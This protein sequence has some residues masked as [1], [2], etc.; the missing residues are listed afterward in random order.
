MN[1]L[2]LKAILSL[3]GSGFALGLKRAES[4]SKQFAK[5]IKGEFARAFGTAALVAYTA[6]LANM[7]GQLT[8]TSD[9]LGISTKA[10]QEWAY[11]A[12]QSGSSL[13]SITRYLEE[14][15]LAR[16]KALGGDATALEAFRKLGVSDDDLRTNRL[17]DIARQIAATVQSGNVQELITS[18]REIGGKTAG[19]LVPAMQGFAELAQEAKIISDQHLE[20]VAAIGD[21]ILGWGDALGTVVLPL[22]AKFAELADGGLTV[23]TTGLAVMGTAIKGL[24]SGNSLKDIWAQMNAAFDKGVEGWERRRKAIEQRAA[25]RQAASNFVPGSTD[26]LHDMTPEGKAKKAAE[27]IANAS[28]RPRITNWQQAGAGIKFMPETRHIQTVAENTRALV[29]ETVEMKNILRNKNGM[30][31]AIDGGLQ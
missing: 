16:D 20:T 6:K 13:E 3:N 17:E 9:R 28:I 10:L 14:L 29:R 18:L 8:E 11:A 4:T 2:N 5:E 19:E 23:I 12:R 25:A 30:G 24:L 31:A 26:A 21:Q 1:F 22:M 7:A 27:D 15:S